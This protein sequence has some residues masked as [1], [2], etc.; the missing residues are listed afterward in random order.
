ML[1][2]LTENAVP[3]EISQELLKVFRNWK[4]TNGYARIQP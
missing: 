2:H 4:T 3:Q 1:G